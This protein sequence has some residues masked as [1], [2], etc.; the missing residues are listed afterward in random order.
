[1][2]KKC[3]RMIIVA[4]AYGKRIGKKMIEQSVNQEFLP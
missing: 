1:M 2:K 4:M 3:K